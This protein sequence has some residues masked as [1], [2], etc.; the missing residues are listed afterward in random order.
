MKSVAFFAVLVLTLS[1]VFAGTTNSVYAADSSSILLTIAK[2]AQNQIEGQIS[3]GTPDQIKQLF[4]QGK[5]EVKALE[6]SLLNEET[7]IA[8]KQF[9]S[10]MKIFSEITRQL[11]S[12]QT[13]QAEATT[14][15]TVQ[16]NPSNDLLRMQSYVGNLKA[17]A[18]KQNAEIDFSY[19]NEL[20][21]KARG[22][23]SQKQYAEAKQTIDEIKKT[24]LEINQELREKSSQQQTNRAQ[25]FAQKYLKQLDRLIEHS[26][27]TGKSEEIIQNLESS[28]ENL[29]LAD[30]PAKVIAEVRN[31]MK[32]Q[33]TFELYENKLLELRITQ[34]EQ[35]IQELANSDQVNQENIDELT[36]A[37][38]N[39]KDQ[40]SQSKFQEATD[41]LGS[42][43]SLIQEFEI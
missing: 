8:K 41:S 15:Q 33:Q 36:S 12:S 2:R 32:I 17:I 37:V 28:K 30:S 22:Q 34:L 31:I 24:I 7:E 35:R 26:Q 40:L 4:E 9:L 16:G 20:F 42:L 13:S 11:A 27:K 21:S 18:N 39:I 38:D 29:S 19:L 25:L 3:D 14:T 5:G 1:L 43:D 23:I 6:E 10:A